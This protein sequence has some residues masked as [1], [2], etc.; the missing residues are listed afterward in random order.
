MLALFV[1]LLCCLI[2]TGILGFWALTAVASIVLKAL[3]WFFVFCLVVWAVRMAFGR[4]V[5]PRRLP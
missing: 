4:P 5:P 3:F 1:L 2:V